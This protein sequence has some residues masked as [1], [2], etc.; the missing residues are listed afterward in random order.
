MILK[1]EDFGS[2]PFNGSPV[3][4]KSSGESLYV[5]FRGREYNL[6]G[7]AIEGEPLE[8]IWLDNPDIPGTKISI[9]PIMKKCRE[10]F[11]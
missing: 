11:N 4:I 7:V 9:S 10:V 5:V 3:K 8:K 1:K 6:N 2:W